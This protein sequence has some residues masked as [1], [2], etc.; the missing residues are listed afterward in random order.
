MAHKFTCHAVTDSHPYNTGVLGWCVVGNGRFFK[1]SFRSVALDKVK[2][3]F[4]DAEFEDSF[5]IEW[6]EQEHLRGGVEA[7]YRWWRAHKL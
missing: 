7:Y 4:P 2:L 3:E 5:S 6:G 1:S